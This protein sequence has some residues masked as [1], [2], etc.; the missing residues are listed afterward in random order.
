MRPTAESAAGKRTAGRWPERRGSLT[1][2]RLVAGHALQNGAGS[3][4]FLASCQLPV[5]QFARQ[6]F[7]PPLAVSQLPVGQ[8]ARQT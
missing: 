1:G 3:L 5:R 6:E 2:W 4:L 8:F 7:V